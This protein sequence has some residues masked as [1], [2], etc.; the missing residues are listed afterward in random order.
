MECSRWTDGNLLPYQLQSCYQETK[1]TIGQ[2]LDF[3]GMGI[4]GFKFLLDF[5]AQK[6]QAVFAPLMAAL[7]SSLCDTLHAALCRIASHGG[8]SSHIH[9]GSSFTAGPAGPDQQCTGTVLGPAINMGGID[10]IQLCWISTFTSH[11]SLCG[12]HFLLHKPNSSI[13]STVFDCDIIFFIQGTDV[14][15][16]LWTFTNNILYFS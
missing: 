7:P 6:Q 12:G 3:V 4:H 15:K 8:C 2:Y 9:C 1:R 11:F 5:R 14:L 13:P 16:C 10:F